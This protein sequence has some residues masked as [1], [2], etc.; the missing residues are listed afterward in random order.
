MTKKINWGIIGLGKIANK[1]A[2]D[3]QLS[4]N[5]VL[6]AV[7][8]RNEE[9]A[10][11]FSEKYKSTKFYSSYKELAANPEI[12]VIYI[13]TPNTFH[14]KN[15]MMCLKQGKGVLCE[16]PMGINYREVDTMIREARLRNLFLMEGIWTRFIPATKKLLEIL[17]NKTIGDILFI[18][19]DFGF[20]ADSNREGRLYNKKLGGG[21]LLDVGIYPI[22]LSLISLGIPIDIKAMARMTDTNVDGYCS[23]LFDYENGAKAILE[24][25]I[26]ANT[27]TEATI[28]GSKGSLKLHKQFHH[29]EKITISQNDEETVLDI[30]HKG[31]GY[32][33]EIEEVNS[34]LLNNDIESSKLPLKISIDM[35]TL[36][37]RIKE[38]IGLKYETKNSD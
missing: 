6:Y 28:Y 11:A 8:S 17:D 14:F 13:A 15:T 2:A 1:F 27:P 19:A 24:S 32:T 37:D 22:Y 23:M 26:E 34:C 29:S 33:H 10:K 7:A 36:I 16:K 30:K 18:H 38:K 12:D 5:A 9:K 35:I 21:S 31:N 25:T 4:N 20:K 3:L